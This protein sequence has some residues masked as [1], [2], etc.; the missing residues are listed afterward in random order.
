MK[1]KEKILKELVELLNKH[2]NEDDTPMDDQYVVGY[3]RVKDDKLLGY[4]LSTSCQI[5]EEILD[6]KRYSDDN[7]YP[8]LEIISKNLKY[9]L[10]CT[11]EEPGFMG[12]GNIIREE[13]F[14][15][16][17]HGGIYLQAIY[18]ADGTPKKPV[19]YTYK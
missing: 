10:E 4:H 18:L 3:Y 7:P 15:G 1:D 6:G 11:K 12:F 17:K 5:T 2:M 9:I 8:Q 13:Y 14:E 19:M 16:Y